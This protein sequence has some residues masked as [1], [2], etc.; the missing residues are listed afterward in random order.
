MKQKEALRHAIEIVKK[1]PDDLSPD[2][3]G[4]VLDILSKLSK[5]D[6]YTV[7]TKESVIKALEDWRDKNGR[8]PTVTDLKEV[9]MPKGE[10]FKRLFGMRPATYLG[11]YYPSM[12]RKK[13][14]TKFTLISTEEYREIFISQYNKHRP[15]SSSN[16]NK[17]KDSGTPCWSTIAYHCGLKSWS[18]LLDYTKVERVCKKIPLPIE[19]K[20]TV[21]VNIPSYDKMSKLLEEQNKVLSGFGKKLINKNE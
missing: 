2:V 10:T 20:Y 12:K 17:L 21:T 9:N 1:H 4:D 14:V 18:E 16:Y 5:K 19:R 13:A 6:N 7:W 3:R 8:N 11:I 15:S